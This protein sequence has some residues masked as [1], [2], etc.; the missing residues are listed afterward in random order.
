MP[1]L[2]HGPQITGVGTTAIE[3]ARNLTDTCTQANASF[4]VD[5]LS[6]S[7]QI[8]LTHVLDEYLQSL[9]QGVPFD[10][11]AAC[12]NEPVLLRAVEIYLEK[13]KSL[14][15]LSRGDSGV[16]TEV[17]QTL[18]EFTLVREI[19]RG[20]MGIVYEARQA[21]MERRVALKLLPLAAT[22]D[23][24]QITRFQNESRAAGGLFHANIVPVYSVGEA[25]GVHFYAMQFIDGASMDAWIQ[26]RC[27][28]RDS[29]LPGDF[30][31][32][33]VVGWA[34]DCARGLHSAH[35]TGVVHRDI[36]PS[37]LMLDRNNK[38]W[39]TDFGLARCQS[40]AS[41]TRSGDLVGTMRYMSPEQAAGQS[42]LVDGRTD[43]YSLAA[44]VYEL[45][46]LQPAHE[47]DSAA[48]ILKS[49]DQ[50]GVLPLR[51]ICPQLPRDLET[52][53]GKA[54]AKPRDARY[55]T[56]ENFADDLQRVIDDRPTIA[57]PPTL[58]DQI[59]RWASKH[60]RSV[61][62]SILVGCIGFF[63]FA[64]ST[65]RFAALKSDAEK[66]TARAEQGRRLAHETIDQFGSRVAE[67]LADIP[68]AGGVRRELLRDTLVYY[69]QL[70]SSTGNDPALRHT[71]AVT[72]GKIGSL[73]SQLNAIEEAIEA[74]R[75]S[76]A[77][78]A[79][80]AET[81]SG[82]AAVKLEWS[83][84]QNNLAQSLQQAGRLEDAG[85]VYAQAMKLQET[86]YAEE[87]DE[88][89]GRKLATTLNNL[90]LLLSESGAD[91][92]AE[93]YF[94]RA[95]TLLQPNPESLPNA[96][97][98]QQF[99]AVL[100]N[101]SGLLATQKPSAAVEFTRQAL[102]YQSE[103]LESNPADAKLATQVVV[104][105]NT[106]GKSL[107]HAGQTQAAIDALAR[108]IDIGEQLVARWPNQ[109]TYHRDLVIS[110]NL[111]GLSHSRTGQ[112]SE[113]KQAFERA[114]LYQRKLAEQFATD[115]ETQS[116][117]GGVLNNLGFLYKQL[118][119][120]RSA[121][122]AFDAAVR[123]QS[124]AVRLA[125]EVQLYR[126]HLEKHKYNLAAVKEAS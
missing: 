34:V 88:N 28:R 8:R 61:C 79:E 78:Y 36:K 75:T 52:V 62:L 39:I 45:L 9:E 67:L 125:P 106:L 31:W 47:G 6:E 99:A 22:L 113:A 122:D 90:A 40:S 63:G 2:E 91:A 17:P 58:L 55:E 100:A 87:P 84:S 81:A 3:I 101:L 114:L 83:I 33:E 119:D 24:R 43:I 46:T 73:H 66:Q 30:D 57:R 25:G 85:R 13:L 116:M 120:S 121:R 126:E 53:L 29:G 26:Q 118:G 107:T 112:L 51:K 19:G 104:T 27:Q 105:L 72:Y 7:Q 5:L 56:A 20:G 86:L 109:P 14:Y 111:Y 70:A 50:R 48:S 71:L 23:S 69:E 77:L 103:A 11:E 32:R 123:H 35:E 65:A 117:L 95:I 96:E 59:T 15:G 76:E 124:V 94:M 68:A 82:G 44:T 93:E 110:L 16:S 115:A 97:Q 41:L 4:D 1:E 42:A 21:G 12:R 37:N 74:L 98:T 102:H 60:R 54:L 108:A 64:I 18:G 80:L 38:I 49:I 10:A 92:M 89:V